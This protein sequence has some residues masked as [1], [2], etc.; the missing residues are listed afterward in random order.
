MHI[1]DLRDSEDMS[2]NLSAFCGTLISSLLKPAL[3]GKH[4]AGSIIL[5]CNDREY[6]KEIKTCFHATWSLLIII[7]YNTVLTQST[8]RITK[9]ER[10]Y[11]LYFLLI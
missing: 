10:C 11:C 1:D 5:L 4:C 2:L 3:T 9:D 8:H 7:T 6:V